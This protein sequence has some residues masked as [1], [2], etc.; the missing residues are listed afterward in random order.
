MA[1]IKRLDLVRRAEAVAAADFALRWRDEA[2]QAYDVMADGR[3]PRRL[4]HCVVRHGRQ[5]ASYDG[6]AIAWYDGDA[7]GAGEA[8]SAGSTLAASAIDVASSHSVVVEER[9][10]FGDEWLDGL[11]YA[12]EGTRTPLLVG[13]IERAPAL[14]HEEFR[15]YWWERHRPLANRIIPAELQPTAYV[16]NY[17]APDAEFPWDGIGEMYEPLEVARQRAAW[18]GT[19]AAAEV[20][21]DEQRFLVR[22]TRQVLVTELEV[23]IAR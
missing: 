18:F 19:D 20:I 3:R 16:H 4:A 8:G 21:A 17:V 14:T 15:D 11:A 10:V 9:R 2:H 7:G 6:I 5:P 12:S 1:M 23:I 22:S 13:F